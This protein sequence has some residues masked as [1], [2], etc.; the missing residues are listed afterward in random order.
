MKRQSSNCCERKYI[1]EKVS[2]FLTKIVDEDILSERFTNE[3]KSILE[4]I[5]LVDNKEQ[6]ESNQNETS[7][8]T[9]RPE[10]ESPTEEDDYMVLDDEV[11]DHGD[12][13]IVLEDEKA[14]TVYTHSNP[15][16]YLVEV[17][18]VLSK[19]TKYWSLL[20][21]GKLNLYEHIKSDK[22]EVG[23]SYY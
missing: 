18:S 9:E 6:V 22:P 20:C 16:G 7:I 17:K 4:Y 15:T 10:P 11:I 3:I 5:K 21:Q 8:D 2:K 12:E 13:E 19:G 14:E 23:S 1:C